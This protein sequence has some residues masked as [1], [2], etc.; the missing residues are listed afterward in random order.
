MVP[1]IY[2]TS[3]HTFYVTNDHYYR[4]GP[5]KLFEDTAYG[6][7]AP[8]TDLVYVEVADL[9]GS[10]DNRVNVTVAAKGIHNNNGFGHGRDGDEILIGRVAA[11]VLVPAKVKG[12]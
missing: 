9:H 7:L 4:E 5:L 8:R 1:D 3:D 10:G 11:G 6:T 12:G 2:T